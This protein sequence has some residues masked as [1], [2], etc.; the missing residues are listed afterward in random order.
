M[1]NQRH[2]VAAIEGEYRRYKSLGEG[3]FAQM[4]ATDLVVKTTPESLSI[5]MIVWH[6]AGNLESRFTDFLTT[7]GE[8]PWRDRESE[9]AERRVDRKEMLAKWERGWSV[10]FDT[11]A[12]LA[13]A[14]LTR[15]VT[16]RGISAT[17]GEALAR[18]LAHTSYHVGQI[19]FL[20]KMLRRSE[21]KYLSIPPGKSAAYNTNPSLEK[22]RPAAA[23]RSTARASTKGAAKARRKTSPKAATKSP[24]RLTVTSR[25]S[26]GKS[27]AA[28]KSRKGRAAS[29][30]A[31]TAGRGSNRTPAK[32]KGRR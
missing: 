14:E 18:S 24:A 8:K 22:A 29:R 9:F 16:I 4:E 21:W 10:L 25:K 28:P 7:D 32:K 3:T 27:A 15:T 19:T 1:K 12:P 26:T 13:D 30:K 17:V 20:G 23:P 11:L 2:M 31:G 5:A 6:V